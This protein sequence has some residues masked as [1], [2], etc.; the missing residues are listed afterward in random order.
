MEVEATTGEAGFP[1]Q[2]SGLL[3][4]QGSVLQPLVSPLGCSCSTIKSYKERLSYPL[5]PL[6][7]VV[8]QIPGITIP[9]SHTVP[10]L[11]ALFASQVIHELGHLVV[12]AL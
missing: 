10:L 8:E 9:L 7:L 5:V 2:E 3:A 12:A 6:I 1:A 11:L 4:D